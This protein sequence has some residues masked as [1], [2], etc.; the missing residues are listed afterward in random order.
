[1]NKQALKKRADI[2][3]DEMMN[4]PIPEITGENLPLNRFKGYK[5]DTGVDFVFSIFK[6]SQ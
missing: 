3:I 5:T 6:K 1:M 2:I 4:N